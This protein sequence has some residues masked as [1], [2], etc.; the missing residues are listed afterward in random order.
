[1]KIVIFL[2]A[3]L[4]LS[5]CYN[6]KNVPLNDTINFPQKRNLLI[7]HADDSLWTVGNYIISENNLTGQIYR[8]SSQISKGKV[9]HVYAAPAIAVTIEGGKLTVPL[10]NIGKADYFSTDW[11]RTIGTSAFFALLA[12]TFI[13]SFFY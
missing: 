9:V 1:M 5:G 3:G 12:Y 4:S 11:W 8:N 2:L 7:V 10:E 6:L 13:P